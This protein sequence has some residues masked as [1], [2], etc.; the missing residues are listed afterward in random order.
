MSAFRFKN[1]EFDYLTLEAKFRYIGADG[2]NFCEKIQFAQ[3]SQPVPSDDTHFLQLLDS[4]LFLAFY[5]IG[6]SYYKSR[7]T[8]RVESFSLDKEQARFFSIVYQDGLSQYAYENHL[9]RADLATF[10]SD[11]PAVLAERKNFRQKRIDGLAFPKLTGFQDSTLILQSGG[12]DSLLNSEL[13]SHTKHSYWYLGSSNR[14]PQLLDQLDQP[15]QH[16]IRTIDH[17]NLQ[18]SKGYNG[19]VPVTYIVMSLALVQAILNRQKTVFTSIGQEGAEAHAIIRKSGKTAREFAKINPGDLPV[20][21]QWSKTAPAEKLFRAYVHQYIS[22]EL[23]IYSPLRDY[24]ELKIA[25]LFAEKCWQKYGNKFSSCNIANYTQG[26][27]NSNLKWCGNCAKCANSY[28]LFA[29]FVP[30]RKLDDIFG[31]LS[32]FENPELTDDFEGLLGINDKLKPFECI[33]EINE[34]RYAYHH[35]LPEYPDLPFSVP[36]SNFDINRK[37]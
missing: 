11:S 22:P 34:L 1:Y 9:T 35:R 8:R 26:T 31:G 30:R 37:S 13:Q 36:K 2:T 14:H 27:D 15:L 28:L 5:L 6:T 17:E 4:A 29:P 33:G 23:D 21:H 10:K 20:N 19:H 3:P 32:L 24:T 16:A 25:Q 18:K 7:P 12:K